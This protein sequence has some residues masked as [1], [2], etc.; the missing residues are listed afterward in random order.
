MKSSTFLFLSICTVMV[1]ALTS[2]QPKAFAQN[3][4][5]VI[6]TSPP[7]ISNPVQLTSIVVDGRGIEPKVPFSAPDDWFDHMR[8]VFKNQS[9]KTVTCIRINVAFPETGDGKTTPW[10]GAQILFGQLPDY[11]KKR[12]GLTGPDSEPKLA[13]A[14]VQTL[15]INLAPYKAGLDN[16]VHELGHRQTVSELRME[17]MNVYFD[18]G[19]QWQPGPGYMK[20]SPGEKHS[21]TPIDGREIHELPHPN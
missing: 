1:L 4:N 5:R 14:P 6:I 19:M 2:A 8:I 9:Q 3:S 17:M 10:A 15:D 16:A 18:D 21:Y 13:I 11:D 7:K 20:P 12:L